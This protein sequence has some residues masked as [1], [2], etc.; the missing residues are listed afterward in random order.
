[1]Q[2]AP[3]DVLLIDDA[4]LPDGM[5]H[6]W[7]VK[8]IADHVAQAVS[9]FRPQQVSL[10]WHVD[11]FGQRREDSPSM[12][13]V[14]LPCRYSRLTR[15]GYQGTPTIRQSMLALSRGGAQRP[16]AAAVPTYHSSGS[17]KLFPCYASTWGPWTPCCHARLRG[18]T[19]GAS[20]SSGSACAW[21]GCGQGQHGER[22]GRTRAKWSGKRERSAD[23]TRFAAGDLPMY[24]F[25]S[26]LLLCLAGTGACGWSSRGTCTS[27]PVC[28]FSSRSGLTIASCEPGWQ[29]DKAGFSRWLS[30]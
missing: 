13:Y 28:G 25:Q 7:P 22:C 12:G 21:C 16:A 29:P 24:K 17:L 30:F 6:N 1:L 26:M 18:C 2:I 14:L 20:G 9:R 23:A 11:T 3:S 15:V 19:L 5:Q 27:T 4:R 8:A 10:C